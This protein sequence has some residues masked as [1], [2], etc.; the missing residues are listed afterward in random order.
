MTDPEPLPDDSPLW[1][2]DNCLITPHI[3]N[4]PEMGLPLIADRVEEDRIVATQDVPPILLR[5][6]I[7]WQDDQQPHVLGLLCPIP[8]L[9]AADAPL[10][11]V[12][13]EESINKALVI[14]DIDN[15]GQ[16]DALTDGLL[17]LR[18][19]FGLEGE[20]L[21]NG[22]VSYEGTRVSIEEIQEHLQKHMPSL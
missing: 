11:P 21:V 6:V 4:T 8:R 12:Q 22:V 16:V 3:A 9:I 14:A 13:V 7:G 20:S 5:S 1:H 2:L 19:L 18:Y 17:L 10:T 15:D